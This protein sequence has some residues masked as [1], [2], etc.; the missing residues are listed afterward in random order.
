MKK[1]KKRGNNI[2]MISNKKEGAKETPFDRPKEQIDYQCP[3]I[4]LVS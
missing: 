2:M 1:N 3:R 4:R